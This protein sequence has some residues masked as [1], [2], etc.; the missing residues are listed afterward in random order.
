MT[1]KGKKHISLKEAA[2]LSGYSQ[3]YLGQLIRKGK[4]SGKKVYANVA[5]MTTEEDLRSYMSDIQIADGR[6]NGNGGAKSRKNGRGRNGRNGGRFSVSPDRA[7][8]PVVYFFSGFLAAAVV[9]LFYIFSVSI[10][11]RFEASVL[12]AA[13]GAAQNVEMIP[14]FN[15]PEGGYQSL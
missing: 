3:D 6:K 14:E 12:E 13:S 15:E 5:W 7:M 8:R 4:L 1:I 10:D 9:V 11:S 2:E